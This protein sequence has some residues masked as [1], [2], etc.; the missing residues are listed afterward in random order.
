MI[1]ATSGGVGTG[2]TPRIWTLPSTTGTRRSP[3]SIP[4]TTTC[5]SG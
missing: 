1:P 5:R 3:T 2:A 4:T